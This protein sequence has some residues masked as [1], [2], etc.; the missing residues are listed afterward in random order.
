MEKLVKRYG[1]TVVQIKKGDKI[2]QILLKEHKGYLLG[3]E[4]EEERV[5][6]F[7]ST[8]IRGKI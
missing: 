8:D 1:R 3:I 2:A 5:G 4:T 7:G 6:G